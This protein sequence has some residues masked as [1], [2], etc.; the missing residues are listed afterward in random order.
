MSGVK[1]TKRKSGEKRNTYFCIGLSQLG[2][3][4]IHS[5]IKKLIKAHG[6]RWLRL[7]MSYHQ[8]LNI[9]GI[10]QGDLVGKIRKVIG[11][12]YFLNHECNFNSR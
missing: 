8:C 10:L 3:Y 9:V 4:K 1:K 11:S 5:V 6:L 7:R 2:W 12:N